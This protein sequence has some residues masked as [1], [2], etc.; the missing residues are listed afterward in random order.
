MKKIITVTVLS[1]ITFVS[2]AQIQ[3]QKKEV[4]KPDSSAGAAVQ[5]KDEGPGEE[6]PEMSTGSGL[7]ELKTNA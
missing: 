2:F 3:R 5:T 6:G 7:Q 1:L 4:A